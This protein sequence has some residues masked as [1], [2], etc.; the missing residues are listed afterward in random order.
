MRSNIERHGGRRPV[1]DRRVAD[2][3]RSRPPARPTIGA[4]VAALGHLLAAPAG[5][6]GGAELVD[7]GA[8][9]VEV[10]LA[11]DLVAGELDAA[12]R[13]C[14]RRRR[15]ARRGDR[16]L[17]G[18]VRRHE[19]DQHVAAPLRPARAVAV[20]GRGDLGHGVVEPGR[21][22]AQVDEPGARPPRPPR[23]R[24]RRGSAPRSPRRSAAARAAGPARAA[25]RRVVAKSPCDASAG[26]SRPTSGV[27][28]SASEA[29]APAI[30]AERR[31]MR[32]VTPDRLPPRMPGPAGSYARRT[33]SRS[34][35][36]PSPSLAGRLAAASGGRE[37]R[38]RLADPRQRPLEGR[39]QPIAPHRDAGLVGDLVV[40]HLER[41]RRHAAVVAVHGHRVRRCRRARSRTAGCPRPARA[42]ARAA[43][44]ARAIAR[45]HSRR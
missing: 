22:E 4:R 9:V 39:A 30:G 20:A 23:S 3:G 1:L 16:H 19:L 2:R 6:H 33:C 40:P 38:R 18:R 10:V 44:R 36:S 15:C 21:R 31:A 27:T 34:S 35:P 26:R 45:P 8:G 12:A 32:S 28:P 25:A 37:P 14:R 7:L 41:D 24:R 11:H 17:A 42:R 43:R 29:A 5:A 13:R